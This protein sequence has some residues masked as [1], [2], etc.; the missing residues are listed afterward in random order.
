MKYIIA[1]ISKNSYPADKI[2]EIIL[3]GANVLRFNFSHGTPE[4]ITA[5]IAVA[6][7]V[8][9]DVGKENEVVIMADLP[10]NKLRL[11]NFTPSELEV[12]AGQEILFRSA[13]QS[14]DPAEFIPVDFPEIGKFLEVGQVITIGDGELAGEVV[15][16]PDKDSFRLRI[17]NDRYIPNLKALNIGRAMDALDHFT[18][19]ALAH[20]ANLPVIRP[21]WVAFSFVRNA[22]DAKRWRALVEQHLAP[23]WRPKFMA[24][25][26]TPEGVKNAAEIA[27]ELDALMVARGDLGLAAPIELLGVNQKHIVRAAKEAG[28]EVVVATQ[29]LDSLLT[30]YT[31]ERAEVLDLTNTVLDGADGIML[32]KETGISQTPGHS[33]AVA[34]R[35]IE[36]VEANLASLQ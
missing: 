8:I 33:V 10:G 26:E 36:A 18:P 6:R 19:A 9:K 32:A 30:Y 4:D 20:I 23:E 2:R 21:E 29:I 7:K 12:K 34:R 28:K 15:S 13:R 35:I 5:K 25:I 1:T 22:S 24:K 27:A 31:P 16:L 17:L 14:S 11:G 3:A